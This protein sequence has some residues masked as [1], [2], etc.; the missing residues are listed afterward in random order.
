ML[1]FFQS[2]N[3]WKVLHPFHNLCAILSK[4]MWCL[5]AAEIKMLLIMRKTKFNNVND[6]KAPNEFSSSV[7]KK[8]QKI[9]MGYKAGH[10]RQTS[11]RPMLGRN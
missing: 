1:F 11:S 4:M 7:N 3:E 8:Q 6:N 5:M 9:E 2:M 10:Y